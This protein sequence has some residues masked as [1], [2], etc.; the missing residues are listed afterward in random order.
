MLTFLQDGSRPHGGSPFQ[1]EA[2]AGANDR[3]GA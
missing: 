2:A 3:I 1:E